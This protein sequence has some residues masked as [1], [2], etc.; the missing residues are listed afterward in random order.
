MSLHVIGLISGG[1]DSLY[2]LAHCLRNGH[3]LV[4]LANLC[5]ETLPQDSEH[6]SEGEDMNS[7]MYQTVGHSIIPLYA[8]AL[9]LPLYRR[10]ISGSATQT[11]RYYDT[12]N[13][14]TIA[15]ETEDLYML[16]QEVLE[17]HPEAN[18]LCS[19]AVLSTYQRTR[20]E[21][22][23]TRHN[24]IPLSYLWQYPVLPPGPGGTDSLTGLLDDMESAGCD[25]RIIKVAS[26]GIKEDLMFTDVTK[27]LI[28]S[29]IVS[30][31]TPFFEGHEAWLRGAVIGEGGEYETLALT[32]PR[33][34][35]KRQ[36][37]V[38][39]D[40]TKIGEGGASY[41]VLKDAKLEDHEGHIREDLDVV[42]VPA[43][44]DTRFDAITQS[45][46][47]AFSKS[48]TAE[49]S[50]HAVTSN[51]P[52]PQ[53]SHHVTTTTIAINNL[54]AVDP[55][56]G[57]SE[58]QLECT[59]LTASDQLRTIIT[60]LRWHLQTLRSGLTPSSIVHAT[61]LLRDMSLFPTVNPI[62]ASLW[63]RGLPNP[64]ARVTVAA[65]LPDGIE[66]ALSLM[67]DLGKRETRKGLHV[68]GRSYWAP[69]NIGPYSQAVST[70]L[71]QSYTNEGVTVHDA[72]PLEVVHM[73]GQIPLVPHSMELLGA[74]DER[75]EFADLAVLS[76]QHLWRIGQE[77]GVDFWTTGVA[78]LDKAGANMG[79]RALVA[80]VTWAKAH[81][82]DE[83]GRSRFHAKVG[84]GAA[85]EDDESEDESNQLDVWDLQR[86][87]G[88]RMPQVKMTVGEHLH[89]L[90]D[91]NIF[92][93]SACVAGSKSDT[94][95]A[96]ALVIAEMQSLPR[97][98]SIEWWSVGLAGIAKSTRDSRAWH[99]YGTY[100]SNVVYDGLVIERSQHADSSNEEN[101][102]ENGASVAIFLT[103]L[104]KDQSDLSASDVLSASLTPEQ[105][106]ADITSD[107]RSLQDSFMG[108]VSTVSSQV[109]IST[110]SNNAISVANSTLAAASSVVPCHSVRGTSSQQHQDLIAGITRDTS[111]LAAAFLLRFEITRTSP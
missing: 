66:V 43:L 4:A 16:V 53:M 27:S 54:T 71:F 25:A 97:S 48:S 104:L 30:G 103:L 22:V 93:Q 79:E 69:A 20:V 82:I 39:S 18:A 35:W 64:P 13:P 44:L 12:S 92:N 40:D 23:A 3:K 15:D 108:K 6:A 102:K 74:G 89:K 8:D 109:F 84:V 10:T 7:F 38:V 85:S 34:L 100:D 101:S 94:T 98:A 24:L 68:Q 26:G 57:G 110:K 60:D 70:L 73:A 5:P 107:N 19:G 72:N 62:Y 88:L 59:A 9:D 49:P 46:G 87:H 65:P 52:P 86:N 78:Y 76:L 47:E 29:R 2:T 36:I 95:F 32:G 50:P 61:L 41:A 17:H 56:Q 111:E 1:K 77:R 58:L 105:L 11:G 55:S 91:Y 67:V 31:L 96:P 21:S 75:R 80:A 28:K 63:P 37:H 83:R 90:P 106:L 42:R 45:F 99:L 51:P 14:S 81:M 33:C